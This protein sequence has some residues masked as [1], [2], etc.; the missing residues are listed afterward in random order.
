LMPGGFPLGLEI[1]NGV[2]V[3]TTT[4]TSLGS[5]VTSGAANAYGSFTQLIASTASDACWMNIAVVG[6]RNASSNQ[7]VIQ[8]AVGAAGSEKVIVHDLPVGCHV[9]DNTVV[10]GFPITIPS[11]SRISAGAQTINISDGPFSVNAVLFDG[12]FTQIEGFSGVDSIGFVS[13]S[14]QGTTITSG[15]ANTKGSYSQLTA[16]TTKDYSGLFFAADA[17][18]TSAGNAVALIDIAIGGSGSEQVIAPNMLM[19]RADGI[20][21]PLFSSLIFVPIP[22]GTRV[23]ARIQSDVA[24]NTLGL[25]VFGMYQ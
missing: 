6:G 11:G 9:A 20:W 10:A 14:T 13:A 18:N 4:A 25:T 17:L 2:D 24:S 1:C 3:G 19:G 23:A 7:A 21:T 22:S 15:A 12:S 16:S 8:I 5:A